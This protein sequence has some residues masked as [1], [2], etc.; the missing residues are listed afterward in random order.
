MR[1]GYQITALELKQAWQD[2]LSLYEMLI[3]NGQKLK[4]IKFLIKHI[5]EKGYSTYYYPSISFYKLLIS[6]PKNHKIDY[7]RT[8]RVEVDQLTQKVRFWYS[9]Y[10]E[11][12]KG[13]EHQSGALKW[14]TV[15]ELTEINSIFDYFLTQ[16]EEWE[17]K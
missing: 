2:I 13:I 10:S 12:E 14:T 6:L 8:L 16:F 7:T 1:E 15:C 5:I 4:P 9:N 3:M 17:V 11:L